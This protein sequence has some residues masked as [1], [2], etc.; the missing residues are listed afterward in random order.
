MTKN[1]I[2]LVTSN[3]RDLEELANLLIK[4]LPQFGLEPSREKS[5]GVTAPIK[6]KDEWRYV[7]VTPN[8]QPLVAYSYALNNG[9]YNA[10]LDFNLPEQ[11]YSAILNLVSK[12]FPRLFRQEANV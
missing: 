5:S 4:A 12:S 11:T 7:F 8:K 10:Q 2:S 6:A 1:Q 9:W 3:Q